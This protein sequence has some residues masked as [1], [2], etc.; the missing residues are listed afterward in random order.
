MSKLKVRATF[1]ALG[2]SFTRG[3]VVDS[4][5]PVVRGREHL[6]ESDEVE[7][8]TAAPGETRTT[9]RPARK[10]AAKPKD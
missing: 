3:T 10:R 2:R 9:K 4:A 7:Q 6:F 1:F 5:D 8:A